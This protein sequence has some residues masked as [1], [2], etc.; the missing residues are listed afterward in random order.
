MS[1]TKQIK[2]TD[3]EHKALLKLC[4]D[5]DKTVETVLGDAV[6]DFLSNLKGKEARFLSPK[7]SSRLR[8]VRISDETSEK[9]KECAQR[10]NTS[11]NTVLLNAALALL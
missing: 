10:Q 8:T 1:I 4:T 3:T 6:E 5:N 9:L 7:G 11:Q 2:L